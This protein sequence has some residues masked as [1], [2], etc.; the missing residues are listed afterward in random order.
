MP[1]VANKIAQELFT[2]RPEVGQATINTRCCVCVLEMAMHVATEA[3]TVGFRSGNLYILV[4]WLH[5]TVLFS[6]YLG[7]V[8]RIIYMC[9]AVYAMFIELQL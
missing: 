1:H 9:S 7:T 3:G 5:C 4:D 8:S 2:Q 6:S